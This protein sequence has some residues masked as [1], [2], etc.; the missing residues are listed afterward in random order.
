VANVYF[1]LT[2]EFNRDGPVVLLASGQAVVY[3]RIAIMSKDGD[4][5]IR[6]RP[7]ACERVRAVLA[8]HGGR[9]RPSPPLDV[10]WLA[11]G[12]SSHFEFADERGRRVRCDFLSRP[13]RVGLRRIEEEFERVPESAA[14]VVVDPEILARMKQT[15]RA[16]DYPAIAEIARLLPPDREFAY[17][18]DPDRILELARSAGRVPDRPAA[19]AAREGATR[20][21]VVVELAREIDR[22]QRRDADRVERYTA[23]SRRYLEE[24]RRNRLDEMPLAEA[25][26]AACELAEH[27]LP[28]R[29]P[30]VEQDDA[31]AE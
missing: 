24:F 27:S 21:E 8:A 11:G 22:M 31:D 18:T 30:G 29:P 2:R 6:E 7:D 20:E 15:Q 17:T 19:R 16:K 13:P 28:P 1:E 3:Y 12:W 9:H 26:A 25:H 23:A 14:L 10:R 4:W 5:V